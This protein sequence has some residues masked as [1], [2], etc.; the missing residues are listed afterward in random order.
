MYARR[1]VVGGRWVD[2]GN[3]LALGE[4]E[5]FYHPLI[6]LETNKVG[7]FE[8]LLR[9][10]HPERGLIAPDD[11]I[12]LAEESGLIVPIGEW[13][14]REA[15]RQIRTWHRYGPPPV[16]IAVNVSATQIRQRDLTDI[17]RRALSHAG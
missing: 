1:R 4:V 3:A 8:A 2:L 7:C 10:K 6:S 13:V 15:C 14:V 16:R 11:F 5:V 17:V 9:W 12:P